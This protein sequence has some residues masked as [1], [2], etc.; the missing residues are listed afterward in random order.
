MLLW[1]ARE[2]ASSQA[3]DQLRI[4][5][6]K[7]GM[8][9]AQQSFVL[10]IWCFAVIRSQIHRIDWTGLGK[11]RH[12]LRPWQPGWIPGNGPTSREISLLIRFCRSLLAHAFD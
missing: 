7:P 11:P 9:I 8:A 6:V 3:F 5:I 2:W 10:T 4:Q 12:R 1:A